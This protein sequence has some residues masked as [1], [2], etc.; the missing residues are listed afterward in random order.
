MSKKPIPFKPVMAHA[1]YAGLSLL[2][3]SCGGGADNDI[4][5]SSAVFGS[6][7]QLAGL[8]WQ[9]VPVRKNWSEAST[10]C[11]TARFNNEQG[12]RLPRYAEL[13]FLHSSRLTEVPL[14]RLGSTWASDHYPGNKHFALNLE[15]GDAHT[16]EDSTINSVIC[17]KESSF[18]APKSLTAQA[19]LAWSAPTI[20]RNWPDAHAFCAG[21]DF[22]GQ[23]G[24]RLPEREELAFLYESKPLS[25]QD[26]R[27][28]K[29][30]SRTPHPGEKHYAMDLG[31][32]AV[33]A[34]ESTQ[35]HYVTCVK[36]FVP[37]A[38]VVTYGGLAWMYTGIA[39]NWDDANA[40]C[41]STP[42]HGQTGWHLPTGA[43]LVASSGAGVTGQEWVSGW[44]WT[45]NPAHG[46]KHEAYRMGAS[47][48][49][50]AREDL[51]LHYVA[52]VYA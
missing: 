24:W 32:G 4:S 50:S 41:K 46:P 2:L 30:W 29:T 9:P 49:R 3:A 15:T 38:T 39:R 19:G 23:S 47:L 17:V 25:A 48:V 18:A 21:A 11:S 1:A 44:T 27:L 42:W 22:G 14:W 37:A 34:S 13:T 7:V 26:W 20:A 6:P 28:E 16:S 36:S 33:R 8:D 51:E 31:T 43:E 45:S 12:W 35:M 10:Y 5:A 40:H 52:C